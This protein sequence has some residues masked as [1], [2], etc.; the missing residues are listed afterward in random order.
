MTIKA[1]FFDV[2]GVLQIAPALRDFRV[3]A[4]WE[5]RLALLPGEIRSRSASVW[6]DGR[7]GRLSEAEVSSALAECLAWSE[8]LRSGHGLHV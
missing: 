8:D 4:T 7:T 1:V 3:F 2:G 6:A 5:A